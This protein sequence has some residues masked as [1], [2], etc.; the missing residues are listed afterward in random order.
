MGIK[1]L[2]NCFSED[3]IQVTGFEGKNFDV[4]DLA[5]NLRLK[6]SRNIAEFSE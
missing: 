3:M 4:L 2:P 5:E 6:M 1:L